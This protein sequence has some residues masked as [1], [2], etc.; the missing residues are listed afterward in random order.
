MI[1][2]H[3]IKIGLALTC[4]IIFS[5][6]YAQQSAVYEQYFNDLSIINPSAINLSQKGSLSFFYN[7]QM[8]N[9]KGAPENLLVNL[10]LPIAEKR[11]GFGM[12]I[13]QEKSG[14]TNI[15]NGY[16]SYCY[17]IPFGEFNLNTGL[18][19]GLINQKF[20]LSSAVYV[21]P[22]DPKILALADATRANKID[23]RGGLTL[24][25]DKFVIGLG[26]KRVLS[27][28]FDY[29]YFT[30]SSQIKMNIVGNIHTSY[31]SKLNEE[32]NLIPS[33]CLMISQNIP[34]RAYLN[35]NANYQNKF[36]IGAFF[37]GK[38][39]FG[40]NMGLNI[41]DM[42]RIGYSTAFPTSKENK[43]LGT[44]S[45]AFASVFFG[46]TKA[47]SIKTIVKIDTVYIEKANSVAKTNKTELPKTPVKIKVNK[48]TVTVGALEDIKIVKTGT[49][50]SKIKLASVTGIAATPSYYVVIGTYKL[51]ENADKAIKQMFA[52]GVKCYKFYYMPNGY[53]YVFVFKSDDLDEAEEVKQ[54]GEY[55]VPDIWIKRVSKN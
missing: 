7:R 27:P 54:N 50:T 5:S 30:Y 16:I 11:V 47:T 8:T 52:N 13:S 25:N 40:I 55:N 29:Q 19:I 24:N 21:D 36:W 49:D 23:F 4:L 38:N 42:F 18:S 9:L 1:I 14:F 45:E 32:W 12:V 53:Y 51:Q 48:D 34:A 3:S 10:A 44:N 35:L 41:N 26:L 28:T 22:D 15:F 33:A 31:T 37:G 20:D 2:R 43:V 17:T 6:T 46:E 39:A